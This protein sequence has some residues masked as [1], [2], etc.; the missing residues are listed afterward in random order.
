MKKNRKCICCSKQYSY[1]PNCGGTDRL[2]PY[3]Y[4]EF[5]SEEC[6]G[7]WDIA[8]RYNMQLI[9]KQ[10]AK[11]VLSKYDLVDISKY[12]ACVQR[13]LENIYKEEPTAKRGKRV[14]INPVDEAAH[15]VVTKENE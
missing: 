10:E 6:K 7:V 14:E 11:T 4:S 5:C 9:S 13:D 3:W 12:V 8:T 1:C 15:E 2:K